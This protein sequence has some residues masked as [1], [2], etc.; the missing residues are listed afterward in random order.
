LDPRAWKIEGSEDAGIDEDVD[1]GGSVSIPL[2]GVEP[3]SYDFFCEYHPDS[4]T[5]TLEVSE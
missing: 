1:A 3:G 2:T 4:M 5:G